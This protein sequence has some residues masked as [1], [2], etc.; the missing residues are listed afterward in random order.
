MFNAQKYCT[1]PKPCDFA[2]RAD[3]TACEVEAQKLIRVKY[4]DHDEV[5]IDEQ[6]QAIEGRM[7]F[8]SANRCLGQVSEK[9]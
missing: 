8:H 1:P 5:F 4:S 2:T 9:G 3:R 6:V 7:L